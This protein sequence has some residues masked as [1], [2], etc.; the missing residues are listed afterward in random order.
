MSEGKKWELTPLQI[1]HVL[2]I[3]VTLWGLFGV[4]IWSHQLRHLHGEQARLIAKF[5]DFSD[6]DPTKFK[7]LKLPSDD[8]REATWRCE[9]PLDYAPAFSM[10]TRFSDTSLVQ[11]ISPL[12]TVQGNFL[13]IKLETVGDELFLFYTGPGRSSH[14]R[15]DNPDHRK[16]LQDH[17]DE[18]QF[19]FAAEQQIYEF[20]EEEIVTLIRATAPTS[21]RHE[22]EYQSPDDDFTVLCLQIGSAKAVEKLIHSRGNGANR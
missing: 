13:R 9:A 18:L 6:C 15:I 5:G 12:T 11:A 19:E 22:L 14:W 4:C 10:M 17:W 7:L 3:L 8:P 2:L 20:D 21:L 1:I 16:L